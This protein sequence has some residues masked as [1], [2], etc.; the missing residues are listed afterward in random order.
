M[1][2]PPTI[3]TLSQT[4]TLNLPTSLKL[5]ITPDQFA[6]LA[7]S[8]RTLRLERT[9]QGELSVNPPTGWETGERNRSIIGQ[10]DRWYDLNGSPGKAFDSSTGFI[11]PNG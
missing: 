1:P 8:N 11:L 5:Q 10:L 9:A 3:Q 6:I 4:L 2:E 7:A